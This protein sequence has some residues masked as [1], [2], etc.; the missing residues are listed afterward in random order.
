[1]SGSV[2]AVPIAAV[3][4]A[5]SAR[6]FAWLR[7]ALDRLY[8]AAGALGAFA[9]FAIA[10]LM[11]VQTLMRAA[12]MGTGAANDIVAWLAAAA[13]FLTMAHAFKHGDFVRVSL[14]LERLAAAPRR[15]AEAV[16]LLM[17]AVCTGY[18]AWWACVVTHESWLVKEVAQGLLAMPMWLPQSS[19]AAGALLLWLAVLDEL[20][21]VARGGEPTYVRL[22]AERHAQGDFSSDL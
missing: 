17:G 21:I 12:G 2:A 9:V 19:F 6:R 7:R 20:L 22:V 8:L 3:A 11:V 5:P 4:I 18:L 1:V 15:I 14:L 10:V 16:T 13:A